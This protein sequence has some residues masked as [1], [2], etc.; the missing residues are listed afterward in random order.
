MYRIEGRYVTIKQN[1]SERMAEQAAEDMA[2]ATDSAARVWVLMED[3]T[4]PS[5]MLLHTYNPEVIQ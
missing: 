1:G 3:D 5:W 2:A 4:A